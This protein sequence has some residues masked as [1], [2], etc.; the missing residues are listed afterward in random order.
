MK[1]LVKQIP[2]LRRAASWVFPKIG[3]AKAHE[4]EFRKRIVHRHK[5]FWNEP[6]AEK[7][8]NTPMNVSDPVS[9]WKDVPNWQRKLSNKHNAREFA[10]MHGCR[11]AELYWRGRDLQSL[12]FSSLPACYVIRPTVGHSSGLVFLMKNGI[13]LMDG[14]L[15]QDHEIRETLSKA[16]ETA[17]AVEFLFEEFLQTEQGEYKIP[18]DYKFYIFNGHV[19]AIQLINRLSPK[20]GYTTFYDEHWQPLDNINTYYPK[21]NYEALPRCF[22]DMI[23]KV[24]ELSRSYEIFARIDFYATPKGAVFGEFTPTPFLGKHFTP[25]GEEMLVNYWDKYCF[26]KI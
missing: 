24:K 17:P 4:G 21:G 25:S 5:I 3:K 7:V 12:N 1:D 6:N 22:S 10:K 8:R 26:E 11:V 16:I 9:V 2:L 14:K 15:Y 13:N 20:K 18:N 19:A 23:E